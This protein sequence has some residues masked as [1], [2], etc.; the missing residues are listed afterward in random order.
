MNAPTVP[1]PAAPF[2]EHNVAVVR[3]M[4]GCGELPPDG[5]Q[6]CILTPGNHAHPWDWISVRRDDLTEALE[7]WGFD[8]PSDKS[9]DAYDRLRA[10]LNEEGGRG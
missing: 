2:N 3:G 8:D 10:A 7:G 6:V 4:G 1:D 9:A 5:N